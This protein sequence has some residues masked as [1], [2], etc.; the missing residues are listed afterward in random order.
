MNPASAEVSMAE[1]DYKGAFSMGTTGLWDGG[2]ALCGRNPCL[3]FAAPC[4]PDAVWQGDV[5]PRAEPECSL[6]TA[7]G[8]GLPVHRPGRTRALL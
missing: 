8:E 4:R 6:Q 2:A 5:E 1:M 3:T 7:A